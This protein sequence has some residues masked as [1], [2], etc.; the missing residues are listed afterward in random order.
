M[1]HPRNLNIL[2]ASAPARAP[3]LLLA[4]GHGC[5]Q[6]MWQHVAQALPGTRRIR[7][8]RQAGS[9]GV[10]FAVGITNSA[11]FGVLDAQRC[12]TDFCL[13]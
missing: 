4:H 3:T 9:S 6:R 2:Q 11:P 10:Y 5:D 7:L 1:P 8:P 12:M 13:V